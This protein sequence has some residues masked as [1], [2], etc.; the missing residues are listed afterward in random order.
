MK[1]KLLFG[2]K[3]YFMK[4]VLWISMAILIIIVVLST[5]V[6]INSQ[7]LFVQNQYSANQKILYQVK[8]NMKFM[9]QTISSL[10]NSLYLNSDVMAIMY[11]KQENI[12]DVANRLNKVSSSV[13]S[14]NP[15]IH[16]ISIYNP[17]LDHTYHAGTPMFFKDQMIYAIYHSNQ[18]PTKLKPIFRDIKKLING[19]SEPEYVF[20]Y[21][22]YEATREDMKPDGVV[23]INVQPEWLLE[24][25]KQINM[26]DKQKGD[27][28]FILDQSGKYLDDGTNDQEIMK[29]LK[30]DLLS[31]QEAHPDAEPDGFFQSK[32]NGKQY[33]ITYTN[34]DSAGMTLLKTQPV[35]EVYKYI[36]SLKTS[37]IFIT[38]IFLLMALVMS[39]GISQTIYRP[40]GKLVNS[41][42]LDRVRR[43][44]Q[45]EVI[46][47]ISYLNSVYRK[48][49]EKLDLYAKEKYQYKDVMKQFWLRRLLTE[50][51]S[52]GG[53]ELE[54]VFKEMRFSL[55]LGGA[56]ALC[57]LKI[58]NYPEFQ[59]TFNARD[60]ETIRF[61]MINIASEIVA[62]R[63]PNEGLD[64]KEDHVLLI[65]SIPVEDDQYPSSMLALMKEAQETVSR[66]FK[67]SF[68]A[69]IS[70]KA[71][72]LGTLNIL[73]NK[74]LDQAMYRLLLG[75]SSVITYEKIKRNA[76]SKKNGYSKELEE[77]LVETIKSGNV[78]SMKEVLTNLF[79]ELSVLNYHNAL[80]SIIGLVNT[81]VETL[82]EMKVTAA[83]SLHISSISRHILEKETMGEIHETILGALQDSFNRELVEHENTLNYFIVDT[84][85]EYIQKNYQDPTLSLSSIAS[86][87]KIS[88]RNLSKI[89][90]E[91][92]QVSI[93]DFINGVRLTKAAELLIQDDL[94]VYEVAKK[95][96]VLNETYFFS[97]FK[98]KYKVTP[99]EYALQRN[100]NRIQ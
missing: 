6:Y 71:E 59:S 53:S 98:K 56:Y 31:Y 5:V 75:H 88:S 1:L 95:V 41:I 12:V 63:Y 30:D 29:W 47:E 79:E 18:L 92:T 37:I 26:I 45:D 61:A 94:S 24:N 50:S 4:M 54:A 21:F 58:D 28:I 65:V 46:D 97:L 10:S 90:K 27:N 23:V 15:Y 68:T 16:S 9:D 13:T 8:Y 70:D 85:T 11:A 49:M 100:V 55:P 39:I 36:N 25:I 82:E 62:R 76:E 19:K 14:A 93:P 7:K 42:M 17:N 38:L 74:A 86:M 44:D 52:I 91:A 20:S 73:Y 43:L 2:A 51:L 80:V 48:S 84:V 40:L 83:P 66:F 35:L 96:G 67:V 64:M 3:T 72:G 89:Y 87:M 22:I 34:V 32:H 69:S 81:V 78:A 57:L 99:K 33:L 60:K 77:W